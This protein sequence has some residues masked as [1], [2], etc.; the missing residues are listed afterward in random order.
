MFGSNSFG[1]YAFAKFISVRRLKS[2]REKEYKNNLAE[3]HMKNHHNK[4]LVVDLCS[5]PVFVLPLV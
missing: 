4:F 5:F 2:S 1:V 3:F